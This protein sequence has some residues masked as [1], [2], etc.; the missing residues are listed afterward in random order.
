VEELWFLSA[1][2]I[3]E[4][5][6]RREV[7]PVEVVEGSLRRIRE[8]DGEVGAFVALREEEALREAREL[9][10]RLV[11]GEGVGRLAGLPLGVKDLEDVGGLATTYGSVP[12]RGNVAVRDSV[13]V[14]RLRRA[15]CVVVGKT[16][17]PE[18]GYT[19]FTRNLLQ[20]ETRNP[21]RLERTPGGSSGGSAAAVAAGMVPLATG[22]DG[23]GSI[24]IP[25]AYS[26]CY[27][28]KPQFGRVPMGPYLMV[29]WSR[30]VCYGPL[31]R[32]VR[33]A[34]LYLDAVVGHHPCDPYSLPH[35]GYSYVEK[36]AEPLPRL[37]IAWSPTL[38]YAKV[39][40][41]VL[42]EVEKGVAA[43]AEMGHEIE[44][45]GE[46]FPDPIGAWGMVTGMEMWA[47]IAD[48][49]PEHREEFGR[50]FLAVAERFRDV[51]T[52]RLARAERTRAQLLRRLEEFF[53]R[54]DLLLT[55]TT[56]TEAIN[57]DGDLPVEVERW[58]AETA[59]DLFLHDS[60]VAKEGSGRPLK[61]RLVLI[62]FTY[63]FNFSGHPAASVRCGFTDSGLPVG[64]Q[65]VGPPHRD[66]LV[67]Q[68]SYAFE[69]A[70]P[71]N[72]HWPRELTSAR[73]A[74]G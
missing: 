29:P 47:E 21:W 58:L 35:P 36:L 20:G 65:I 19:F 45:V 68:A 10:E 11:R 70:R 24:R 54:F 74:G 55:P 56:A 2:E 43:F 6:R 40:P 71:W 17:T 53:Q 39:Q 62:P 12:F 8:V 5:V 57:A 34:A 18:F 9:G 64:L 37:R 44:E 67:L 32:T 16:K 50:S 3:A 46:I 22:S 28:I 42:R 4:L 38:G 49:V 51:T 26:G 61:N 48:L 63:P 13:Q 66:D 23:G 1:W 59:E 25:A 15:G 60:H 52:E 72:H 7:S 69:Q 41:D 73:P 27:G 31:V 33:D 14:E 30:C